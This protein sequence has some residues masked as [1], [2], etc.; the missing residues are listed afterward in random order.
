M[1]GFLGLLVV[2][3]VKIEMSC[4]E[5]TRQ[6]IITRKKINLLKENAN[7]VDLTRD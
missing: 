1:V 2:L 4:S 5:R 6:K 7:K 3:L